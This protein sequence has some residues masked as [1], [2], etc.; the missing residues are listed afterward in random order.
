M[1][2]NHPIGRYLLQ[3]AFI[4]KDMHDELLAYQ[5][6]RYDPDVV[7]A[8]ERGLKESGYEGAQRAMGDLGAKLY[9]KPGRTVR[10][11]DIAR[12]YLEAGDYEKAI[13]WLEKAYEDHEPNLPYLGIPPYDP[14]RSYPRFQDLLRKMNLP[15][16]LKE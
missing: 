5:R 8:L 14:L 9:G 2:P 6:G 11:W 3:Q 16:E 15:V 12:K 10:A 1:V 7:D 13:D 4:M